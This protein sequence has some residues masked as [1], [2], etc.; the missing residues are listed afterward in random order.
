MPLRRAEVTGHAWER[1]VTRW[2][3][4]R[5]PCFRR[6][7]LQ[8]MAEAQEEDLGYGQ[9]L[10]LLKNR[11]QPARYFITEHWRFVTNEEVTVIL[12]IERPYRRGTI[13]SQ[14]KKRRQKS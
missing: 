7:L 3:G 10:R 6:A 2:E 8:I 13:K 5:P 9:V 14:K 12:T 11:M 4:Q 1:F